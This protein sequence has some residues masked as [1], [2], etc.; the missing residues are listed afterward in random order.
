MLVLATS[1][2]LV[3][4]HRRSIRIMDKN[5]L[6]I[7]LLVI[8]DVPLFLFIGKLMFH[9]WTDFLDKF[10]WNLMPDIFS[11]LTGR[12]IKDQR[13]ELATGIYFM[14]CIIVLAIELS[15]IKEFILK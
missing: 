5:I 13:G 4:D 7:I 11:L 14:I 12:F 10:K 1:F 8:I 6:I 9:G 2:H 15:L 3:P